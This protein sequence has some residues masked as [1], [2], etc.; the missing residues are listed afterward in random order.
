MTIMCDGDE[1]K[2][3]GDDEEETVRIERATERSLL[4]K[5]KRVQAIRGCAKLFSWLRDSAKK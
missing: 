4:H 2:E 1:E 5:G 3:D